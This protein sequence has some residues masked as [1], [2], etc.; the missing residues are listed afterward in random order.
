MEILGVVQQF[1]FCSLRP[2]CWRPSNF[3]VSTICRHSGDKNFCVKHTGWALN[4]LILHL[5]F[6]VCN[7]ITLLMLKREYY[8]LF[9]QYHAC[10]CPGSQSR[11]GITRHGI[12]Q[13]AC[14]VASLWIWS[15]PIE[16]NPRYDTKYEYIITNLKQFT[17]ST[18]KRCVT[19]RRYLYLIFACAELVGGVTMFY[20]PFRLPVWKSETCL[21]LL[22]EDATKKIVI[23]VITDVFI[24]HSTIQW[25]AIYDTQ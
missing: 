19:Y 2:P 18:V 4:R 7:V 6:P 11:P 17:V 22:T 20:H 3:W 24:F 10:W 25:Y 15:S 14:R 23:S 5:T 9:G 21:R 12:G 13:G 8:D 1:L 16:Q